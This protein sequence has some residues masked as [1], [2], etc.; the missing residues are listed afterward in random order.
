MCYQSLGNCDEG[1]VRLVGGG[2]P[3]HGRIEVCKGQ[4]WG[5]VCDDDWGMN[6]AR[7]VCRQLSYLAPGQITN[8]AMFPN[9]I[10]HCS[11][12][13]LWLSIMYCLVPVVVQF[14]TTRSDALDSKT[15][16]QNA[17]TIR[18]TIAAMKKTL[19]WCVKVSGN[20]IVYHS[21]TRIVTVEPCTPYGRVRLVA[22]STKTEG[23]VEVCQNGVWGTVCDDSWNN[24]D[25]SVVCRQLG[26]V[27]EG[28][29]KAVALS[30]TSFCLLLRGYY[31]F[32]RT[33]PEWLRTYSD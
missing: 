14:I 5:T 9:I 18:N 7:V 30:F 4:V 32:T 33:L 10:S 22:G 1:A 15:R 17:N 8:L 20:D 31:T 13:V 28:E 2:T 12:Q 24:A 23:R 26:Y 11:L 19:L 21:I 6:D 25:A 27:A 29:Q 16:S 3:A